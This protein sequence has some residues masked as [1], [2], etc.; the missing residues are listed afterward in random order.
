MSNDQKNTALTIA[1]VILY[2]GGI[3]GVAGLVAAAFAFFSGDFSGAGICLMASA[4]A[5]GLMAIAVLREG[6]PLR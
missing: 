3:T 4:L 1:L 2:G 5:F 6:L